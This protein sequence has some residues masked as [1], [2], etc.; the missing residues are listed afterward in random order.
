[1]L[2]TEAISD[3][4]R[5]SSRK[6]FVDLYKPEMEV[7]VNVAQDS[8][9][10]IKGHYLGKTWL[11][12]KDKETGE[13]W[14]NFR[15]PYNANVSPEYTDKRMMFDLHKHTE[16]IGMTGWNWKDQQSEWV[17]YDLDSLINHKS[18]L[19]DEELKMVKDD[20]TKIPWV[21][22]LKST[23]GKGLHIY[24][25]F[26]K[27]Y[28]TQTHTEHAA[29]SRAVL[30]LMSAK[31]G[32]NLENSVDV[33][34]CILWCYHRKIENTDGLSVL[35]QGDPLDSSKV[36]ANW[37]D[38]LDVTSNRR[39]KIR[40]RSLNQNLFDS[41]SLSQKLVLLE[42]EHM[43]LLNWF[44]DSRGKF[45]W[46]WDS[47]HN[48]L[49]CHT[50]DLKTAHRNLGCRGIFHTNSSGS[51][52]QNCFAFP[53]TGGSWIV[54]RHGMK[55]QEHPSWL[56]DETG[57]TRC[58]FNCISDF[59]AVIKSHDAV[60]NAK[61]E[62]YTKS[63]TE[64]KKILSDLSV[65]VELPEILN[66]RACFLKSRSDNKLILKI[67][68]EDVDDVPKGFLLNKKENVWE[69]VIERSQAKKEPAIP[70]HLIRFS[71]ADDSE[72]GWYISTK[73]NW[74]SH[75][76]S[77]ILTVLSGV[78]Q[79]S[80]QDI[81]LMMSKCILNPWEVV[82]IPFED[83][84]PGDRKWNKNHAQFSCEPEEGLYDTW[85]QVL[86]HIGNSLDEDIKSDPWCEK[87]GIDSGSEYL[88]YWIA[89]MFQRPYEPLP[90]LFFVGPQN[91]GKSTLHEALNLLFSK[92]KGYIRADN[93]LTNPSGFNA[94]LAGAILCIVEE[95]NL[96]QNKEANNRIKDWVTGK[97][98]SINEKY[99]TVYDMTNTAH[100]MQCAN[101]PDYCPV[102][103]D[104]TRIVVCSVGKPKK[105]I[106]KK[107]LFDRLEEEKAFFLNA[108]LSCTLPD[109]HSRLA[110][111]PIS[112]VEKEELQEANM[113]D[114]ESF[115]L[116]NIKI[117]MGHI[118]TFS[119]FYAQFHKQ[120]PER[121]RFFW[122]Q[123]MTARKFPKNG[124]I[125]KGK[126][127]DQNII[128]LGNVSL[129]KDASDKDF[130]WKY[131]KSNNRI[132]KEEK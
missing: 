40:S 88:F 66:G 104:D 61:G 55:T 28:K 39:K 2:R 25:F 67:R 49:V 96:K 7:Q 72:V 22:L 83:E 106:P 73:N 3:F 68:R 31:V 37:K 20:V 109:P 77:N 54:R 18:G 21:T 118:L 12:W 103:P 65:S 26:D 95:T 90:Y 53:S 4:L 81:D 33:C 93:A 102:L 62:W 69:M 44:S 124:P 34:G 97:T 98:I 125:V 36:P 51:S 115:M 111:P 82:N 75:N 23:S 131:N 87:N 105:D 60:E 1:M 58:F 11:G 100:W 56:T 121:K 113:N 64:M 15:I 79:S 27:P 94:E 63:C 46:W 16:S 127:G 5:F 14:K 85:V 29:L 123:N 24:I 128:T 52:M 59:E 38:H 110:L 9:S 108:V 71:I 76:R 89:N 116:D 13:V 122:S 6:F 84:Y 78:T 92:G 114:L 91:G 132:Y 126:L 48:M 130:I 42:S 80:K 120:L 19:T 107:I 101:D 74:V 117:V 43:K 32:Y 112:T 8:G 35:V 47:D 99:K 119:E 10:R 45:D 86:E 57:W 70:D 41:L 50:I 17:G 30:S 129:D